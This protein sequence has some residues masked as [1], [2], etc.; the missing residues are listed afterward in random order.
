MI[1]NEKTPGRNEPCPCGS[2]KKT[3][4]CCGWKIK[5]LSSIP[6][7]RRHAFLADQLL[8]QSALQQSMI[9][10]VVL[11]NPTLCDRA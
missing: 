3:K 9:A 1:R 10:P 8:A 2:G 6:P 4:K 7:S 11:P 5:I